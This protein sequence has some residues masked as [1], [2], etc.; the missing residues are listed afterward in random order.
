MNDVTRDAVAARLRKRIIRGLRSGTLTPGRRL[1]SARKV[2]AEFEADHR[3]VLA[4]Y[5]QLAAEGLVELRE[6]AGIFVARSGAA[7]LPSP[8]I[9][10]LVDV[11]VQGLTREVPVVDLE[12]WIRR[13]IRTRKLRAIVVEGTRDQIAGIS[14]ELHEDY[15]FDAS[16]IDGAE[17][18][19]PSPE[20]LA[21]IGRADLLLTTNA[22]A[23]PVQSLGKRVGVEVI[24]AE[25]APD[26]LGGDWRALLRNPLY[27]IVSDES[28]IAT[29]ERNFAPVAEAAENLRVM[30]VGR[31][32]V[33]SIP[34]DAAVYISRGAADVL[35][36]APV[37]G[38]P[39]PRSRSFSWKSAREIV[40]FIVRLNLRAFPESGDEGVP[41]PPRP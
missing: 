33:A 15:G 27:F 18:A 24:V 32:D 10:W 9:D 41:N 28:S 36:D 12:G 13:A 37:G 8:G 38:R 3:V 34:A 17:L 25:V 22:F 35:G 40:A 1:P 4:A 2:G 23:R 21:E 26:L 7:L 20:L 14:R 11:F 29:T 31:D 30:L 39:V 6:R 16:G 19:T 5:R